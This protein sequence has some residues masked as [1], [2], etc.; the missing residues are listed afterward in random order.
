MASNF[1][2]PAEVDLTVDDLRILP[3]ELHYELVNGRLDIQERAPLSRLGG[4]ALLASLRVS[5]PPGYTV[6]PVVPLLGGDL[7]P[8]HVVRAAVSRLDMSDILPA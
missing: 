2:L 4:L 7:P 6:T 3:D 8:T 1:T 5:C